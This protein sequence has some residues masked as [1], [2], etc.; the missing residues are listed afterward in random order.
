MIY[1]GKGFRSFYTIDI[2]SAGQRAAKLLAVKVGGSPKKSAAFAITAEVC[3]NICLAQVHLLQCSNH[4]QSLSSSI[5]WVHAGF[6]LSKSTHLHRAYLVTVCNQRLI[7]M[8]RDSI[9]GISCA[10]THAMLVVLSK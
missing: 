3:V 8:C 7:A 9:D 10:R 1:F 6:A 5:L 4:S 2:G